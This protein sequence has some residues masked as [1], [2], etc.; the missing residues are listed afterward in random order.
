MP[1]LDLAVKKSAT[2]SGCGTYR[3]DLCRVWRPEKGRVLW[4]MLNPSVADHELDDPTIR[5][6]VGFAKSWGY[7][8]ITVVNLF[9]LRATDPNKLKQH[10]DP[11]GPENDDW[12][13][14]WSVLDGTKEVVAAWGSYVRSMSDRRRDLTVE[15]LFSQWG[16]KLCCL[17]LTKD[18]FPKHPL[19]TSAGTKPMRYKTVAT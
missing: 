4:V 2:L 5:R 11:V 19:Y 8:G 18:G 14:W 15:N 10:K 13:H 12:I 3:Y 1:F 16:I 7:G 6:C 17:G 9:A